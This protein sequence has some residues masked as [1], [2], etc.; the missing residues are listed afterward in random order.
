MIEPV[1]IRSFLA[2]LGLASPASKGQKKKRSTR[3]HE[4]RLD[5]KTV[6]IAVP[7]LDSEDPEATMV[8]PAAGDP[9]ATVVIPVAGDPEATM[10]IPV[11]GDPEAT[12]VIPAAGDP[13][14][15]VVIP[16]AGDPEATVVIPAADDPEA[17]MVIAAADDAD[18]TVFLPSPSETRTAEAADSTTG[19]ALP[20]AEEAAPPD[21]PQPL[22]DS[23]SR[24]ADAGATQYFAV[25]PE[26]TPDLV[27]V[28]VAVEGPL[29][30]E[31]FRV[32][33]GEN[34]IG[35]ENC[36]IRLRSGRV[37]RFHTRIT[38]AEGRFSIES[39]SVIREDNPTLVN[40]ESVLEA[41]LAD[42]D[43]IA[44]G[45]CSLKFRTI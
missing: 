16:A 26:E 39:N 32:E 2:R 20:H 42:G 41:A 14:A 38:H 10:V 37:S 22:P 33:D 4:R 18:S 43:V 25:T 8:I 5:S 17:T 31:I 1:G 19:N 34:R 24:E 29:R 27:A 12:M 15:T 40:G 3:K 9:E 7:N 6:R 35:R 45:D 21:P 30:G 13:E 28:L 36:N 44:V 11:A 23:E